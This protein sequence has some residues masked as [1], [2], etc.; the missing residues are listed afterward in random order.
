MLAVKEDNGFNF[1]DSFV[2][3]NEYEKHAFDEDNFNE[4]AAQIY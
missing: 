1:K 3:L 2:S 4:K